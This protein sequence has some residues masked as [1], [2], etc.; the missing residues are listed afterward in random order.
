MYNLMGIPPIGG[1]HSNQ[2]PSKHAILRLFLFSFLLFS[3]KV[4]YSGYT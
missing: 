4:I 2:G 3:Y 1:I